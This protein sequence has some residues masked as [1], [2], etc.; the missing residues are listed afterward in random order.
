MT[1]AASITGYETILFDRNSEHVATLT[2]NR[3]KVLNALNAQLLSEL[4]AALEQLDADEEIRAIVITG[5]GDRAFA[6]GADIGELNAIA[7][8]IEGAEKAKVGQDL[9]LFI[10]RMRTPVIMAINGFALGGGCELAMA[11]DIRIASENA[12]FGQPEVNLGLIPGYGGSQRATRLLGKGNAMFL[13]LSGDTVDAQTALQMG[14]VERVVSHGDLLVA[15]LKLAET[16]ASKAPL[17]IQACKRVINQGA[18]LPLADALFL[19]ALT[20]GTLVTTQDFR[21]GTSAFLEK[22]PAN[23]KGK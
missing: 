13:C 7:D 1:T 22:R 21:E 20:F 3:P 23:W 8:A 15:A 19:E 4:R 12:K 10:E 6:A 14:L 9:T 11:G 5:S 2:L 17:A 18:D 16:I